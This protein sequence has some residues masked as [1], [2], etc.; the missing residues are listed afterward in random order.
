MNSFS[1]FLFGP[2]LEENICR[3]LLVTEDRVF[4]DLRK[5]LDQRSDF[6]VFRSE[7]LDLLRLLKL[8]DHVEHRCFV[9]V[10]LLGHCAAHIDELLDFVRVFDRFP[11]GYGYCLHLL[12][13]FWLDVLVAVIDKL[14]DAPQF[15]LGVEDRAAEQR[16]NFGAV[17]CVVNI[18][19][20]A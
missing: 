20:K 7:T 13:V 15:V 18:L 17:Y 2:N 10:K 9:G 6:R 14:Q 11:K 5:A 1:N 19:A 8:F 4:F 3:H 16:L 12:H